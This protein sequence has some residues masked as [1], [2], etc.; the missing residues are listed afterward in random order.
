[1]NVKRKNGSSGRGLVMSA[2]I[3]GTIA[4]ATSTVALAAAARA[5]G[6]TAFQ[7]LNATSHWLNGDN[8]GEMR[9]ADLGHTAV[10]F[11]T[12]YA[13]TMFWAALFELRPRDEAQTPFQL[14]RDAVAMSTIAAAVDYLATPKRFTPGWELVLTKRSMAWTYLAMAAG[15]AVASRITQSPVD[16]SKSARQST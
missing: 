5:E 11:A 4:A 16:P 10:G 8:A 13:A 9:Q 6:R 7:P 3:G 2:I 12:H 15:L 1:M 14:G